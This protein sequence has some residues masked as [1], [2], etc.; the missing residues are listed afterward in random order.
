MSIFSMMKGL[1]LGAGFMYFYDPDRGLA[2]RTQ[3]R[4]ELL[5][6]RREFEEVVDNGLRDLQQSGRELNAEIMSKLRPDQTTDWLIEHRVRAGLHWDGLHTQAV[7]VSVRDGEVILTG[8]A[9]S[10]EVQ[11]L[12]QQAS[13]VPG[14]RAVTNQLEA[15]EQPEGIPAL[16]ETGASA[17]KGPLSPGLQ[18]IALVGGSLVFL[19]GLRRGG[20]L[21]WLQWMIGAAVAIGALKQDELQAWAQRPNQFDQP[22]E[23]EESV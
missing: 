9:L 17:P 1:M 13:A 14:V 22:L 21:G 6:L 4:E 12:I 19:M 16:S 2:R 3:L 20:L 11:D 23:Q 18:L 10:D 15:H 8:A 5:E 7:D